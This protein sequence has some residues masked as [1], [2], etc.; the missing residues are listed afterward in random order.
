MKQG[1]PFITFHAGESAHPFTILSTW[2]VDGQFLF[3]LKA[4]GDYT[5]TLASNLKLGDVV[6]IEG[7]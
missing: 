6:E 3:L 4:L 5:Q 2:Q 1:S 7:P